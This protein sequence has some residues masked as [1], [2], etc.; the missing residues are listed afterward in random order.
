LRDVTSTI[1]SIPLITASIVSKKI[2]GDIDGLVL[3]V[4]TGSGAFMQTTEDAGA[5]ARSIVTVC[6]K[7]K[8]KIVA[9][10][11]DM[12]Q[13]LGRAVGNAMEI[14][15][16][17]RFL[18]GKA[19]A[20]LETV[21]FALSAYMIYL[22]G[23]A[24]TL[25]R[26]YKMAYEA[27]SKGSA[28]ERFREI[29]RQQNGDEGVIQHEHLLARADHV[30][31]FRA[32][33]DGFVTRCDARLI[34]LASNALGAGRQRLEDSVDPAVGLYL[35]R[36][37]GDRARRGEVLCEIHWNDRK[38]FQDALPF[39]QEAFEVKAR[40]GRHRPLIHAVLQG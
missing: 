40:P 25:D 10:I 27:V 24:K 19:P 2:A 38:R 13:P 35:H 33:S 20:D 16:C 26:A 8:T 30:E 6:R 17:I 28:L 1:E 36:K 22:G 7:M 32:R 12:D 4:K 3:D 37:V 14:R 21:S 18:D 31:E 23:A 29:I 34:G 15:E 5:L 11:T 39:V 9:I